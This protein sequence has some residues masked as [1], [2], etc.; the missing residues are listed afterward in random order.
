[1][2]LRNKMRMN[3]D[4]IADGLGDTTS[5][6]DLKPSPVQIVT[7]K[8]KY[9][10]FK[11]D[12]PANAIELIE[13]EEHG[14]DVVAQKDLY[15]IGEKVCYLQPDYC[16]SEI[17]LFES[18]IKPNG[19]PKKSKLGSNNRIR[20]IKFNFKK[21]NSDDVVYSQGILM[22]WNDVLATVG[23]NGTLMDKVA[24]EQELTTKLNITKWEAPEDRSGGNV[25]GGQSKPFP[26]GLYKTDEDNI[27]NKWGKITYPVDLIGSLKCDGSSISIFYKNGKGGICSRNLE[28]NIFKKEVT[29]RRKPTFVE[30]IKLWFGFKVD[31]NIYGESISDSD[32]IKVGLPYLQKL[33]EYC[34]I[35]GIKDIALRGELNGK[36]L[37]GSGNKNN[38]STKDEPNIK[39]FGLDDY[40]GTRAIKMSESDFA[41]L[42]IGLGFE[43]CPV[44]FNQTFNSKEEIVEVC[45]NYFKENL[46]EGIV[47]RTL[48]SKNSY[49]FMNAFYDSTK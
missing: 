21:E 34:D 16:L 28:V 8:N 17:P 25:K 20:A 48:D 47:I 33:I 9:K 38:P 30:Q 44:I 32:F 39:F 49:K 7:V 29:G 45:N 24:L 31:L 4:I 23:L 43:R 5:T 46:V 36:G 12:E 22:Q 2:E 18:F 37:K 35:H 27:N 11:G 42:M 19:D 15:E 6:E 14:F 1:M 41:N 13:V 26:E 3:L 10:L 40:S